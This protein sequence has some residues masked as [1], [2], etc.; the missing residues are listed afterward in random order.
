MTCAAGQFYNN[1]TKQCTEC[2]KGTYQTETDVLNASVCRPCPAGTTTAQQ[3][4]TSN[5]ECFSKSTK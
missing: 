4:T 5:S 2:A 3:G 1:M